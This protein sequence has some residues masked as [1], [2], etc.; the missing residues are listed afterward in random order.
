MTLGFVVP[1]YGQYEIDE[2]HYIGK[3][4]FW[5]GPIMPVPGTLLSTT[6]GV[7][8]GG[9]GFFRFNFP[10][11]TLMIEVQASYQKYLAYDIASLQ[12]IPFGVGLTYKLP[13]DFSVDFYVRATGGAAHLTALPSGKTNTLPMANFGLEFSFPTGPGVNVGMRID[14]TFV[15]ESFL[16][17]PAGAVDYKL[18]DGHFLSFGLMLNFDI[19]AK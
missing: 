13:I 18:T 17:P 15:Y 1:V 9:G 11:D 4:G 7:E 2:Q 19:A 14:Y 8:V 12:V 5:L 16:S 10:S 3:A 6:L